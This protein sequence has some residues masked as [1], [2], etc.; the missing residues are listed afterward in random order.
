MSSKFY[1]ATVLTLKKIVQ[2]ALN[3]SSQMW[4]FRS[5]DKP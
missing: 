2:S 4:L 3:L 1:K 5:D